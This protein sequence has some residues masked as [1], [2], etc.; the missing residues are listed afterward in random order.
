MVKGNGGP[1]SPGYSRRVSGG[2]RAGRRSAKSHRTLQEYHT[3]APLAPNTPRPRLIPLFFPKL[4]NY[5]G[6]IQTWQHL[7]EHPLTPRT[8]TLFSIVGLHAITLPQAPKQLRQERR[9]CLA[10]L[11]ACGLGGEKSTLFFQ[12][13]VQEHAELAWYLNTLVGVGKLQRM[14]TW[15]VRWA[16]TVRPD[17]LWLMTRHGAVQAGDSQS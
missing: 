4:G 3:Y 12:E 2:C 16:R 17:E 14:T 13:E 1:Y 5:L 7:Q 9:D 8:T 6:A 15:K 11:L 10:C